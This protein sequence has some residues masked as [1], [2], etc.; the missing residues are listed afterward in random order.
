M[1]AVPAE[2]DCQEDSLLSCELDEDQ[3]GFPPF[4]SRLSKLRPS[5]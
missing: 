1:A 2:Q 5:R 3:E 4:H